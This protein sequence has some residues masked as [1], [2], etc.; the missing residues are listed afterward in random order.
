MAG[1]SYDPQ[2][3]ISRRRKMNKNSPYELEPIEGDNFV[4]I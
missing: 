3:M 2:Q 4:N 1:K